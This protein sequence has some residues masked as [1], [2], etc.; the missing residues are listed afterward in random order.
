[1]YM[2]VGPMPR[3]SLHGIARAGAHGRLQQQLA[4]AASARCARAISRL[5]V[6]TRI[7]AA[8][9][10]AVPRYGCGICTTPTGWLPSGCCS[11]CFWQSSRRRAGAL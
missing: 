1:M 4:A 10:A 7:R 9:S 11:R 8:A 3:P 2:Y 5:A 6:A